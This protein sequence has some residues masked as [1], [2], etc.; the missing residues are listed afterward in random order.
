MRRLLVLARYNYGLGYIQTP[1]CLY[2]IECNVI[3]CT[4]EVKVWV[5]LI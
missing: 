5:S 3:P 1:H 2:D 4:I